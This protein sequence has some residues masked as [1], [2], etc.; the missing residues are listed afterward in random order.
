[1]WKYIESFMWSTESR[2]VSAGR[3]MP[4]EFERQLREMRMNMIH[5][6]SSNNPPHKDLLPIHV[7]EAMAVRTRLRPTKT[8][9]PCTEFPCTNPLF[10]ELREQVRM[11]NLSTSN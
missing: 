10:I 8:R 6:T 11:R 1:M 2:P 9:A 4:V 3:N 7:C 5:T